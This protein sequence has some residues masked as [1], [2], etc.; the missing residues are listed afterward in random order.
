MP[1]KHRGGAIAASTRSFWGTT[2]RLNFTNGGGI[3][4]RY[5]GIPNGH[6]A[7]SSWALPMKPGAGSAY[8][9]VDAK[10][11][12]TSANLAGG[13]ETTGAA[14][15][16]LTGTAAVSAPGRLGGSTSFSLAS[17]VTVKAFARGAGSASVVV[18]SSAIVKG[19]VATTGAASFS[20]IP[21][22]PVGH[23]VVSGSGS[24][25]FV[26]SLT[27]ALKSALPGAGS[28]S[29][30]VSVP[31]ATIRGAGRLGVNL[32]ASLSGSASI[33]AIGYLEGHITPFTELSPKSL[34]DA[35]WSA[36]R[37]ENSASGSFGQ[38]LFD[39]L[40]IHGLVPGVPLVVTETSRSAGDIDQ[41]IA[42]VSGVVTVE[43]S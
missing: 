19:R 32:Q 36:L 26:V 21:N 34:A 1:L 29:F 25:S 23:L 41:T 2:D 35:V 17:S 28:A 15:L 37:E 8:V 33:R 22:N 13:L 20:L 10:L 40:K 16:A 30:S 39:L 9:S 7:P 18:S 14:T 11:T 6:L 43:R 31:P 12:V 3:T 5:A 4:N 38:A 27:G 42:D 24:A